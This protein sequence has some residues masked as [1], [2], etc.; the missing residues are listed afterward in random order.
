MIDQILRLPKEKILEPLA[1]TAFKDVNPTTITGLP[2]WWLS[3]QELRLPNRL[4][5]LRSACGCSI[6]FSMAWMERWRVLTNASLTWAA[7]WTSCWI[8]WPTLPSRSAW[9]SVF[10][11]WKFTLR[12]RYFAV[13]FY[14]LFILFPQWLVFLFG[15]LAALVFVTAI[16]HIVWAITNL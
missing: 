6:A 14:S 4:M 8:W 3:A 7:N 2:A 16:Q 10:T 12:W 5:E 9:R 15:L 11:S 13:V 1:R